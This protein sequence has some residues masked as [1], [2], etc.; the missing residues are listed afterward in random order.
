MTT[1]PPV[2][3][4]KTPTSILSLKVIEPTGGLTRYAYRGPARILK[5]LIV[6]FIPTDFMLVKNIDMSLRKFMDVEFNRTLYPDREWLEPDP[7]SH[8]FSRILDTDER[9]IKDD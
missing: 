7:V 4:T 9:W 8:R 5:V 1:N 6:V 3:C 2:I